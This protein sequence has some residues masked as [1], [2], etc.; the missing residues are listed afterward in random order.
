MSLVIGKVYSGGK[1]MR[2]MKRS[3]RVLVKF[4]SSRDFSQPQPAHFGHTYST[5]L[6]AI[7]SGAASL[8]GSCSPGG[9][10]FT[11][12]EGAWVYQQRHCFHVEVPADA[13]V[14]IEE[15]TRF[16][17][18]KLLI[19]GEVNREVYHELLLK[20]RLSLDNVPLEHR[21]ADIC[22][23]AVA[24]NGLAL[25]SVPPELKTLDICLLALELK[26]MALAFVPDELKTRDLCMW[27]VSRAG[28]ALAHVPDSIKDEEFCIEA[29]LAND[30]A[31]PHV[32]LD[33][34]TIE[35]TMTYASSKVDNLFGCMPPEMVTAR[36]CRLLV[37]KD[38]RLLE[39]VPE[40]YKTEEM[41]FTAVEEH[42]YLIT[43]VPHHLASQRIL[44]AV[45]E[46]EALLTS[47][48]DD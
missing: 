15:N 39:F 47:D 4:I 18:N 45:A 6:N 41:C 43:C 37:N 31:L 29:V 28:D 19:K 1:F 40:E 21:D 7:P 13:H 12:L 23:A 16:K 44:R 35:L 22:R 46:Y 9:F 11:C 24:R 20:H 38:L 10:Y 33:R 34:R 3:G 5:G 27:C 42:P 8:T 14:L 17:T 2:I 26:P 48:E 36:M 25:E 32:P 30:D